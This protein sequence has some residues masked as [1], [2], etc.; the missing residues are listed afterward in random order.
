MTRTVEF[1]FDFLQQAGGGLECAAFGGFF[2]FFAKARQL[3]G[4][5]AAGAAAQ[6]VSCRRERPRVVLR[7]RD[8]HFP[9]A[10]GRFPDEKVDQLRNGVGFVRAAQ[11]LQHGDRR[12]IDDG[13]VSQ[14]AVRGRARDAVDGP[15]QD[16]FERVQ[17]HG[18]ADVVVHADGKAFFTRT[19]HRIA[20]H[21]DDVSALAG[22]V[23]LAG[24]AP[25][26][27]HRGFEAVQFR[28]LA[29][30]ENQVV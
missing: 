21:G 13:I 23:V 22:A 28:Q 9:Q 7:G 4:A 16:C 12:R 14:G 20:R 18:F 17:L 26:D 24:F 10:F 29:I 8:L 6:T 27:F 30:H 11:L 5:N 3:D 1:S 2:E 19:V 15:M 25:A